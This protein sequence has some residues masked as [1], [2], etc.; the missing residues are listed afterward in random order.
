MAR[1]E[2][3]SRIESVCV[4]ETRFYRAG[5]KT[6]EPRAIRGLEHLTNFR[7]LDFN[8]QHLC[9]QLQTKRQRQLQHQETSTPYAISTFLK[10]MQFL[11]Y[12]NNW[13]DSIVIG[14]VICHTAVGG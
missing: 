2:I 1:I 3:A 6:Q 13:R 8:G 11:F 9:Q 7:A 12:C 4:W 14:N 10:P 5:A